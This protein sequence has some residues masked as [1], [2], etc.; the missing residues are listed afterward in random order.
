MLLKNF[1]IET[2][3]DPIDFH[4]MDKRRWDISQN[5]F[6]SVAQKKSWIAAV[7]FFKV[8]MKWKYSNKMAF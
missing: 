8:N 7:L 5:I 1:G 4:C 3:L 6:F 2:T